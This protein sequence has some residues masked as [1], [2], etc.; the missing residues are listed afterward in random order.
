MKTKKMFVGTLGVLFMLSLMGGTTSSNVMDQNTAEMLYEEAMLKKDGDGNLPAAIKLFQQILAE[1]PQNRKIA[2]KAQLQIGL[3]YEK[4]GESEALRAYQK[5]IAEY[6]DQS[7]ILRTAKERVAILETKRS[8]PQMKGD[9]FSLR[10]VSIPYG[11][12]SPDGKWVAYM[13][14]NYL[15]LSLY[16]ISTGNIRVLVEIEKDKSFCPYFSREWWSPSGN[17]IAYILC[18]SPDV[19]NDLHVIDKSGSN[20]RLIFSNPEESIQEIAGWTP[21][22][23]YIVV[24]LWNKDYTASF[25]KISTS[26]GQIEELVKSDNSITQIASLSPDGRYLVYNFYKEKDS[27]NANLDIRLFSLDRSSQID[28]VIHPATDTLIGWSPDGEYILF[29]SDRAG[30]DSIWAQSIKNGNP[31]GEAKLIKTHSGGFVPLGFTDN[32]AFYFYEFHGGEDV[33]TAQIDLETGKTLQNPQKVEKKYSGFTT[34]SFWSDDGKYL[35]YF[36]RSEPK[37]SATTNKLRIHMMENGSEREILFDFDVN[38]FYPPRWSLDGKYIYLAGRK[39]R[40]NNFYKLDVDSDK[41]EILWENESVQDWSSD[42]LFLYKIDSSRG[43]DMSKRQ[44]WIIQIN[45]K[46]NKKTELFRTKLGQRS[47]FPY[48][49]PDGKWIAFKVYEY[50][51]QFAISNTNFYV[52]PADGGEA[53]KIYQTEKKNGS[54]LLWWGPQSKGLF[55]LIASEEDKGIYSQAC[56]LWYIPSIDAQAPRKLDI[57]IYGL[58]ALS[59]NPNGKTISFTAIEPTVRNTWVMENYLPKEKK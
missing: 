19:F 56:E 9:E 12:P 59:I 1:F 31:V 11:E 28:I 49:S 38:Y 42:G 55:F 58:R 16:E 26:N 17:Q 15:G 23:K 4:L 30:D 25:A 47:S 46:T 44:S 50:D 35:G 27:P 33:Y 3:C 37:R 5:V 51:E 36:V 52:L 45:T 20:Q 21:D 34:N 2:G 14:D 39:D 54:G 24:S 57:K 10:K 43:S 53:Q 48:L 29:E 7:E 6:A 22:E 8:S 41:A 32:G 40:K 18:H 13:E